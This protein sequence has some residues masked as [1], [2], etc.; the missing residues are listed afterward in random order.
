MVIYYQQNKLLRFFK[1]QRV[2]TSLGL[3]AIVF[4]LNS[5]NCSERLG[6][7]ATPPAKTTVPYFPPGSVDGYGEFFSAYLG[8]FGEPSLLKLAEESP[9]ITSY[10]LERLSSQHGNILVVRLFLNANGGATLFRMEESGQ[11][12]VLKKTKN[13]ISAADVK[14]FLERVDKADFWSLPTTA[15]K[16]G[17]IPRTSQLDSTVCIVEAV[18][19][20]T[21]HIVFR[22]GMEPGPFTQMTNFLAY[23]LEPRSD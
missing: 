17:D 12:P 10:R 6:Q 1:T 9:R 21:Y 20:G 2:L 13:V 19:D 18:R 22:H 16:S 14:T 4:S 7:S 11:P 3:F 5:S 23:H 8:A 15:P